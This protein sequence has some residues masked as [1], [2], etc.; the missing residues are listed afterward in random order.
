MKKLI[1]FFLFVIAYIFILQT[2]TSYALSESEVRIKIAN[3]E[4]ENPI[5]KAYAIADG[6][7][8]WRVV[9]EHYIAKEN[10]KVVKGFYVKHSTGRM[11]FIPET[12]DL[13][14]L[15]KGEYDYVQ[16]KSDAEKYAEK[17][18]KETGQEGK[19]LNEIDL[20][21]G[22]HNGYNYA[23]GKTTIKNDRTK[24]QE[25]IESFLYAKFGTLELEK[26]KNED[27]LSYINNISFISD[28]VGMIVIKDTAAS[29]YNLICILAILGYMI[30]LFSI[31]IKLII[32]GPKCKSYIS[33]E[34][35][36]KSFVF[37]FITGF[38]SIISLILNIVS[39]II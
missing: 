30:S 15:P 25:V 35:F 24:E 11:D 10:E 37:V 27:P 36:F 18:A 34:L 29:F 1:T 39:H 13:S 28:N 14:S 7:N 21:K 16:G 32:L 9:D 8:N 5:T 2:N 17:V 3:G 22:G 12:E 19:P 38:V 31:A 26:I 23:T 33:E 4:Y 20:S 6:K